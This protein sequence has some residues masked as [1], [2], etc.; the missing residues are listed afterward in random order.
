MLSEYLLNKRYLAGLATGCI[1]GIATSWFAEP[2]YKSTLMSIYGDEFAILTFQCDQ[3]MREHWI[4]RMELAEDPSTSNLTVLRST[5]IALLDCNEY[6]I[7]Q[8][9]LIRLGLSDT[10]IGELV[11][12]ASENDPNGMRTV[13]GIHEIRH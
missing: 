12:R 4:S 7:L 6:D 11:L 1:V 5:E 3:A 8:K 2:L 9:K 10:E 13:I